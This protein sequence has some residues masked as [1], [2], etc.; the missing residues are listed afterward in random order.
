MGVGGQ[1]KRAQGISGQV[2]LVEIPSV[3]FSGGS[4]DEIALTACQPTSIT[5]TG[6]TD[7]SSAIE[8]KPI[9]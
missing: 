7:D 5:G 2:N 3:M 8:V 9:E 1:N 4:A 6:K